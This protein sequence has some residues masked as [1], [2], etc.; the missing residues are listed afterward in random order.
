[1][2][3]LLSRWC[4]S[5]FRDAHRAARLLLRRPGLALLTVSSLALSIGLTTALFAAVDAVLLR[6]LPFSEPEELVFVGGVDT[7]EGNEFPLSF[8]DYD[9]LR[10]ATDSLSRVAAVRGAVMTV[11]DSRGTDSV[12]GGIASA[13]LFQILGVRPVLG[14]RFQAL[15]DVVGAP[16]VV[17]LAESFWRRWFNGES[18]VIGQTLQVED[19]LCVVVGVVPD[20]E[21]TGVS[22]P[23]VWLPLSTG[24]S[25]RRTSGELFDRSQRFLTVVGRLSPDADLSQAAAELD[26]FAARQREEFPGNT[27]VGLTV[28]RLQERMTRQVRWPLQALLAAGLVLLALACTNI[29]SLLLARLLERR[30]ELA[31]RV[32]LGADRRRLVAQLAAETT[33]IV[34]LSGVL[35]LVAAQL[36]WAGAGRVLPSWALPG[37]V[38]FSLSGL[39]IAFAMTLTVVTGLV[40][41]V[42][43]AAVV[44]GGNLQ[45]WLRLDRQANQGRSIARVRWFL[46]GV[47]LALCVALLIGTGLAL[48]SLIAAWTVPLGFSADDV[49]VTRVRTPPDLS[50]ERRALLY[51]GV[52][53]QLSAVPVILASGAAQVVPQSGSR[54]QTSFRIVDQPLPAE[55]LMADY[56]RV[57]GDY[58]RAMQISIDHGRVFDSSDTA[59]SRHVAVVNQSFA[60]AYLAG[61]PAALGKR[62]VIWDLN[63][64]EVIGVVADT[65]QG[66][67]G[68]AVVPLVYVPYSQR[69][70]DEMAVILKTAAPLRDV[71]SLVSDAFSR[72]G[73]GMGVRASQVVRLDDILDR[74]LAPRRIPTVLVG[75]FALF[76]I[77][78]GG[79][80]VYALT[81]F[82]TQQRAA[83]FGIRAALGASPTNLRWMVLG[84]VCRVTAVSVMAGAA[85]MIVA[86]PLMRNLVY[87]VPTVDPVSYVLAPAGLFAVVLL[88]SYSPVRKASHCD[89]VVVL[90]NN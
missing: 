57:S 50:D 90:R 51:E 72:A 85:S 9:D 77:V 75:A 62:L 39:A 63:A 81:S 53:S 35:G 44:V 31:A 22:R 27:G 69:P 15:D 30:N 23:S 84:Q 43:P 38:D 46:L 14:R 6:P 52:V 56:V 58:F 64:S 11:I 4:E 54:W 25:S 18:S 19:R 55:P 36:L 83:E 71:A 65:V 66:D 76:S 86:V 1:M 49:V 59:D 42:A 7:E 21:L 88:A 61:G 45:H 40:F 70:R 24:L 29:A 47:Q 78:L 67:L 73:L 5:A 34:G 37:V 32:A 80:G 48:R 68:A 41:G 60:R 89:P 10:V 2:C 3:H 33:V 16:D 74:T 26:V 20:V 12:E 17:V 79:A 82:V 87:G 8:L 13:E 28:Q